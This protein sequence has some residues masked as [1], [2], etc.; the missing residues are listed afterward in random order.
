MK[1]TL[2]LIFLA[3][4][5]TTM[6]AQNEQKADSTTSKPKKYINTEY[7]AII[8]ESSPEILYGKAFLTIYNEG[9]TQD[10]AMMKPNAKDLTFTANLIIPSSEKESKNAFTADANFK[11]DGNKL[12]ITLEDVSITSKKVVLKLKKKIQD[13][14][15]SDNEKKNAQLKEAEASINAYMQSLFSKIKNSKAVLSDKYWKEITNG[16]IVKG[17]SMDECLL[18]KGK[19]GTTFKESDYSTQWS[20][21]LYYTIYFSDGIAEEVVK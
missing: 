7:R 3:A 12:L 20:Y 15:L 13:D 6:Y 14:V 1:K 2:L 11:I 19:P 21:G 17:M 18:A 16:N 9:Q 4:I 5:C 8:E 10:Y